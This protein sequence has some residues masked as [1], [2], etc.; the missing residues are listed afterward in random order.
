MY[1]QAFDP[2]ASINPRT[3]HLITEFGSLFIA[4]SAFQSKVC[5]PPQASSLSLVEHIYG[6]LSPYHISYFT[7]QKHGQKVYY[8]Q[9]DA[10]RHEELE[11]I[12]QYIRHNPGKS[13]K[14]AVNKQGQMGT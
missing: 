8:I 14:F 2:C 12:R 7:M 9:N 13:R 3:T 10:Y 1:L 4:K 11:K 6:E 5:T